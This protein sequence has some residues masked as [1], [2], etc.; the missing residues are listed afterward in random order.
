M[1]L[2]KRRFHRG[3][4]YLLFRNNDMS[5]FNDPRIVFVSRSIVIAFASS[6]I[7]YEWMV[8]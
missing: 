3:L 6:A 1:I 2:N 7:H 5:V 8:L 4:F